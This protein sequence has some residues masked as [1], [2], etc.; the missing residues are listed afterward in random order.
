MSRIKHDHIHQYKK[1]GNIFKCTK[2]GC[3]HNITN[4]DL[5]IGR[6]A[7]CP[8]CNNTFTITYEHIRRTLIH[9]LLCTKNGVPINQPTAEEQQKEKSIEDM[10]REGLGI[11]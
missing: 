6:T 3:I 7:E 2:N 4:R 8:F 5:I 1:I 9:C 11:G 10:L